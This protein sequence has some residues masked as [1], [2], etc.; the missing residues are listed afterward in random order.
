M[1]ANRKYTSLIQ[2]RQNLDSFTL[3]EWLQGAFFKSKCPL[4][5]LDCFVWWDWNKLCAVWLSSVQVH[6]TG[7]W[8]KK[9]CFAIENIL[10]FHF[11][12]SIF[13]LDLSWIG[14]TITCMMR[15]CFEIS[16][17]WSASLIKFSISSSSIWELIKWS[18]FGVCEEE[19][20]EISL[21]HLDVID[22]QDVD[23]IFQ[24][25]PSVGVIVSLW[26]YQ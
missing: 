22:F 8:L 13:G 18:D 11:S 23:K 4:Q 19:H 5:K 20:G 17:F 26:T 10:L 12:F 14:F 3:V 6:Q 15:S 1:I 16:P 25:D 7:F 9:Y 21:R 2:R 24:S